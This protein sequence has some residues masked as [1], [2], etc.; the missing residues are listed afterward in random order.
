MHPKVIRG[1]VPACLG[2]SLTCPAVGA[3]SV[4]CMQM[5][6]S[7]S[8]RTVDCT[9]SQP[10]VYSVGVVSCHLHAQ[11][12]ASACVQGQ[13]NG[14]HRQASVCTPVPIKPVHEAKSS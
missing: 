14:Q 8:C 13:V 5:A 12:G 7:K 2:P 10:A 3:K 6:G 4:L 11:H 1:G 9:T